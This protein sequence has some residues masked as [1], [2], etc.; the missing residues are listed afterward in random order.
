M[1]QRS[2]AVSRRPPPHLRPH[3][4]LVCAM[5]L[6]RHSLLGGVPLPRTASAARA[7]GS[8]APTQACRSRAGPCLASA[9]AGL[10][11]PL[12]VA[13][14]PVFPSARLLSMSA[15]AQ[16]VGGK[17]L[18]IEK[19]DEI[20]NISI[21]AHIDAGK[22]TCTERILHLTQRPTGAISAAGAPGDV[23]KGST[24]TDFL[25]AERERGIT[26][27]SAAVGPVFWDRSGGPRAAISL[28]D[29]P[30]HI[31]FTIE[32]ERAVR[33]V[34]GS[35]VILD[36][37]EG[38][39]AQTEGV[40]AQAQRYGVKSHLLFVNKLDRAGSSLRRSLISF[41]AKGLHPRPV[42]LI[43]PDYTTNGMDISLTGV[44]DVI[45][46]ERLT[47]SG[48]AGES[49]ARAP[50][51]EDDPAYASAIEAC[52]A[53]VETVAS[54]DETLL[55]EMLLADSMDSSG[56][57]EETLRL[58]IRRQVLVGTIVP[59]FCGSG[60]RNIGIQPLLDGIA[61]FL[62]SPID[63]PPVEATGLRRQE[64][65]K[66]AKEKRAA[67]SAVVPH[68]PAREAFLVSRTDPHLSMLAFKVVWTPQMGAQTF[69]R[70]Y[71]G[72]LHS[73]S[74]L[75]N[76]RTQTRE[77]MSKIF[78][79]YADAYIEVDKLQ[80]GQIGVVV[81][82]SETATGDTLIDEKQ[83]LASSNRNKKAQE[84]SIAL[85]S[86]ELPRITIPPPVFS[87][88]IAPHGK[89]DEKDLQTALTMLVRTDPS[90]RLDDQSISGDGAGSGQSTLSG[91]GELHL[92]IARGRLRDEFRARASLGDIRVSYRET[93]QQ[94]VSQGELLDRA[95]GGRPMKAGCVVEI[96]PLPEPDDDADEATAAASARSSENV[97]EIDLA[98]ARLAE[99]IEDPIDD[100]EANPDSPAAAVER[101]LRSGVRA[102][103]LRGP[104]S[105]CAVVKVK[106]RVHSVETYGSDVTPPAAL[107]ACV[108]RAIRQ[109]LQKA[110]PVLL[111]PYMDVSVALPSGAVGA[112]VGDI[113]GTQQG[114]VVDISQVASGDSV[115]GTASALEQ[116]YLPPEVI[117]TSLS[118]G[119][120]AAQSGDKS[121]ILARA[122]L[123]NLVAYSS[124]LRALSAGGGTFT[125][126][127]HG[128][129]PMQIQKQR[130]VLRE[131][132]RSL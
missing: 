43:L 4:R 26:I 122:P 72:T 84:P 128:F 33:V 14:S 115:A 75:F 117:H 67:R 65:P 22:T 32:V 78:L 120:T 129:R 9:S 37:V 10:A 31:D 70:V 81:G 103:L 109:A 118:A 34:D 85:R 114:E 127:F 52:A 5:R 7:P 16:A 62:P 44:V 124:R 35:V 110:D 45:R 41:V 90:L 119:D 24:I 113:T 59:V 106:V 48:P 73:S 39:E 57:S 74:S 53:L 63:R 121:V 91:M 100:N 80:A 96:E 86:L 94:A 61:D 102:A 98:D 130:N 47:F 66:T 77:R 132:G 88:S 71:S 92:E 58:A 30:G 131:M 126:T 99:A 64:A 36:G 95:I 50:L 112:V 42:V 21:I 12:A 27:Q 3:H 105:G 97:V 56:V 69:V 68:P 79:P 15:R 1:A 11:R 2:S 29:T 89:A 20:R 111:E 18:R 104:L 125:M 107:Q 25:E 87:M 51:A 116:V 83:A 28:V 46:M 55:E 8:A 49:I 40:W 123:S 60:A 6:V 13:R 19:P 17:H 23:D 82:L 108:S 38:A 76:T 93:I 101:A 54:V